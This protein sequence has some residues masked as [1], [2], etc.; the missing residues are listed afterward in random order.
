VTLPVES[1][2]HPEAQF[3]GFTDIDGTVMF[4][5]RVQA[6]LSPGSTAVDVGC[7]RGAQADDPVRLRRELRILRG[8][9]QRVIGI[10]V[11][12]AAAENPYV[13]EF[14]LI[15]PSGRWPL[16]DASA[17]LALA[18]FVLEHVVDPTAFFAEAARVLRPGGVLGIRTI[19]AW[20]YLALAS[21]LV[22]N[23]LHRRLLKRVQPERA[24]RDIF[25]TI[26]ACNSVPKLRRAF[27]SHGFDAAVYGSEAEPAYMRFSAAAYALGLVHRRLAPSRLRVGLIGWGRRRTG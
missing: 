7:G 1:R 18:D 20:S 27:D 12:P 8:K 3:G 25:P 2:F 23:R 26:Y 4:Y 16:N 10:D 6:L 11:D 9:C 17:D 24:E 15:E 14:R 13:D 21:R 22:P 5:A 19:N